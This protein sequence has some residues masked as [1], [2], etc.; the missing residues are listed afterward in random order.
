MSGKRYY[1]LK[2]DRRFFKRHDIRIVE[3]MPNGKDYILF[4]L[5][6]LCESVSHDGELRFSE[7]I[8]YN[9]QMLSIVTETNVDIVKAALKTFSELNMIEI[10]DDGTLY[11]TESQKMLGSETDWAEKK[12]NQRELPKLVN[13]S[14]RIN[15]EMMRLPNGTT[16]YVDE[17]RYGGF[18]MY[19][20][21]RAGGKCE[22][23]GSDQNVVI[24]H[25]NGFSNDPEDLVCLCAKCHGKIEKGGG[26]FPPSVPRLSDKSKSIEK[27]KETEQEEEKREDARA[28][29]PF[30]A[31][32][33]NQDDQDLTD[34]LLTWLSEMS[35]GGSPL[36][37]KEQGEILDKLRLEFPRDEW[38]P[39]IQRS[40]EKKWRS[41]YQRSGDR[42]TAKKAAEKKAMTEREKYW[43]EPV[44]AEDTERLLRKIKEMEAWNE[45]D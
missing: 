20:L 35:A 27:E 44:P 13:G 34:A 39:A 4:Y 45:T 17:K 25:K 8:P 9:E 6:L 32:V 14:V 3:S 10:L 18:G 28:R 22:I 23:C 37:P 31:F 16:R 24:H 2:L 1:W 38:I 29:D 30:S 26:Q 43:A 36:T 42:K 21:D 41:V 40:T 11:M 7:A 12:R 33:M 5:K 19:V 15:G